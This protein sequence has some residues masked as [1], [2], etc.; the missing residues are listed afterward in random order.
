M[1][2]VPGLSAVQLGAPCRPAPYLVLTPGQHTHEV[3]RPCEVPVARVE[4]HV[5]DGHRADRH[6][7][8]YQ[9][10]PCGPWRD[11][12][13]RKPV[14]GVPRRVLVEGIVE[15]GIEQHGHGGQQ[16]DEQPRNVPEAAALDGHSAMPLH[17]HDRH[18]R[19]LPGSVPADDER[20]ARMPHPPAKPTADTA[21]T[22]P[23]ASHQ[24]PG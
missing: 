5:R 17:S 21:D 19:W 6:A 8:P 15:R 16:H 14:D 23:D 9:L 2:A 1:E 3:M 20:V 7:K 24:R 22:L 18:L 11:V 13:G 4:A 10:V 12:H